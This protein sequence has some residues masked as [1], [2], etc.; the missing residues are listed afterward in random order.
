ML[1]IA[2]FVI[3]VRAKISAGL[4]ITDQ[5]E[6]FVLG[7]LE[8]EAALDLRQHPPYQ[9]FA[10]PF[11]PYTFGQVDIA[12]HFHRGIWPPVSLVA[13]DL[14]NTGRLPAGLLEESDQSV[15]ERAIQY[16]G[17]EQDRCLCKDDRS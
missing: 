6:N 5:F 17:N 3:T 16:P 2:S 1:C 9:H 4:V 10:D 8:I 15:A 11:Q 7:Y 12:P 13:I 14:G